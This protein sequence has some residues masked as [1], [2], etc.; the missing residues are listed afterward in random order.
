MAAIIG[1]ARVNE[2][3]S[4]GGGQ[5]GD[6]KQKSQDDWN[7]E[8][9]KQYFYIHK[10]GWYI[11]RPKDP[12]V[13]VKMAEGMIIACDNPNIGY[14]QNDRYSIFKYGV[15]T[16]TPCNCD[17]SSL[18]RA[19][20]IYATGKDVGDFNTSNEAAVLERSG[21]FENRRIYLAGCGV[22]PGDVL[23]TQTKG[24]TAIVTS[25]TEEKPGNHVP[26]NY[27]V[28][29]TYK[30]NQTMNVRT[31]KS[32][33]DPSVIPTGQ[34]V[35]TRPAGSKVTCQATTLVNGKI[36]MYIGLDGGKRENWICADSGT[37]SYIS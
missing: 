7:G 3:G 32:N 26:L 15:Q 12:A 34:I 22:L 5:R 23:V 37:V 11:L 25:R 19:C 28:G 36:W 14:S 4:Y 33:E 31:K 27:K 6:Q 1:S 9:S 17:C 16:A 2:L 18:V 20:I 8:V 21:L 35:G 13:A 30:V 10:K 29:N 24:H